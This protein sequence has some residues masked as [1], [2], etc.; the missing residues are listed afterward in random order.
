MLDFVHEKTRRTSTT[1]LG[2]DGGCVGCRSARG[3]TA[4]GVRPNSRERTGELGRGEGA[5]RARDAS[6]DIQ[7]EASSSVG[8]WH[9]GIAGPSAS[10][11]TK[12]HREDAR[13]RGHRGC[14]TGSRVVLQAKASRSACGAART[15][16][17]ARMACSVPA[18]RR[19]PQGQHGPDV[20]REHPRGTGSKMDP[21]HP[22][23]DTREDDAHPIIDGR[24]SAGPRTP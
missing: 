11:A 15:Y 23:E 12:G 17:P 2:Q 9:R 8:V 13:T 20:R 3:P 4:A 19:S 22:Q 24:G 10:A 14:R 18:S 7:Q 6:Y 21:I 16:P 5:S 1:G